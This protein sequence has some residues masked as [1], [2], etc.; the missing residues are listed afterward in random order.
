MPDELAP[1]I[2]ESSTHA[3]IVLRVHEYGEYAWKATVAHSSPITHPPHRFHCSEQLASYKSGAALQFRMDALPSPL[4]PHQSNHRASSR[5]SG[6][7]V[8]TGGGP[9]PNPSHCI[10]DDLQPRQQKSRADITVS[11]S[12]SEGSPAG[13]PDF[14]S[15]RRDNLHVPQSLAGVKRAASGDVYDNKAL[16]RGDHE[17]YQRCYFM[18][19]LPCTHRKPQICAGP[20]SRTSMNTMRTFLRICDTLCQYP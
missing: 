2:S 3:N 18:Y 6:M 19:I 14:E 5:G 10:D 8:A 15:K 16:P 13:N 7:D 20:V 17:Q 11:S 9:S 12:S 1:N 4:P